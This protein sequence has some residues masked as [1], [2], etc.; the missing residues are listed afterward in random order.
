ME[1]ADTVTVGI[2]L[3]LIFPLLFVEAPAFFRGGYRTD[4]WKL[5]LDEK[6]DHIAGQPRYW[7]RMG[8]VWLPI[9]ALSVAGMT[10]FGFQLASS[11]S[12]TLSYLALG[13]FVFGSVAWLIGSLVQTSAV[14]QAA[15]LR[16]ASGV[17]PGWLQA[18]WS[19]A[20]WSELT[21]IVAANVAFIVWGVAILDTGFP[22]DWMGWTAILLGAITL[23]LVVFA[24]EAFPQLGVIVP[25]ILGV[26]LII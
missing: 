15:E 19:L 11:G 24:K 23:L 13:A 14:K 8:V 3:V 10:A 12:G 1:T 2:V 25:I 5:P 17:T 21:Y 18:A 9:L 20:W 4:F 6:L 7:T 26:A 22:A 16:A